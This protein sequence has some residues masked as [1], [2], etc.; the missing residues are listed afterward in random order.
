MQY[1]LLLLSF[2]SLFYKP[3]HLDKCAL[4]R[5]ACTVLIGLSSVLTSRNGMLNECSGLLN[6]EVITYLLIFQLYITTISL[7]IGK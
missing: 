2:E 6:Y 3:V 5:M 4:S 1:I 7:L